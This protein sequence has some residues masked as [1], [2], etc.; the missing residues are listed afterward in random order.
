MTFI[1]IH[2]KFPGG[3]RWRIT[4]QG[5]DLEGQGTVKYDP[6]MFSRA[7]ALCG[8]HADAFA[9]IIRRVWRPC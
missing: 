3:V 1:R 9:G 7:A 4:P 2:A 6:A 5:V 8:K